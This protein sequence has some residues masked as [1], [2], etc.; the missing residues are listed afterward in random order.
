MK[1]LLLALLLLGSSNGFSEEQQWTYPMHTAVLGGFSQSEGSVKRECERDRDTD[2][3]TYINKCL[4]AGGNQHFREAGPCVCERFGDNS[5]R[6]ICR[7]KSRLHC[8][9]SN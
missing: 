8:K 4:N 3:A 1:T 5:G 2:F 9:K 6:Y 7:A